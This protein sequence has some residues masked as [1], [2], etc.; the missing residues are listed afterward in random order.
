[1]AEDYSYQV[2]VELVA[3]TQT[4]LPAVGIPVGAAG[5]YS[6]NI[7][8]DSGTEVAFQAISLTTGP[9]PLGANKMHPRFS[10]EPY[11]W[12]TIQPVKMGEG[13]KLFVQAS[14]PV[15]VQLVG[16]REG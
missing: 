2:A 4:A 3:D 1:M 8:N 13:W 14:A 9:N 16:R 15:S 6:L 5:T 12:A 11:G 10:V 7:C